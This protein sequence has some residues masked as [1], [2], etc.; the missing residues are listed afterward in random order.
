MSQQPENTPVQKDRTAVMRTLLSRP[1]DL[2]TF[3]QT[4]LQSFQAIYEATLAGVAKPQS[5]DLTEFVKI[6][7]VYVKGEAQEHMGLLF[8]SIYNFSTAQYNASYTILTAL[9]AFIVK[10]QADRLVSAQKASTENK[11]PET[12]DL[13]SS[14]NAGAGKIRYLGGRCVAKYRYALMNRIKS[15]MYSKRDSYMQ[16]RKLFELLTV[17][18]VSERELQ[19]NSDNVD[20]LH[21]TV[22]RQNIRQAL[23]HVSD[24]CFQFFCELEG[25][26]M[27][28]ETADNFAVHGK[29]ILMYVQKTALESP[30][31]RKTW[32][33]LFSATLSCEKVVGSD[34]PIWTVYE[35]MVRRYLAIASNQFRKALVESL[36]PT[37][38]LA[39]RIQVQKSSATPSSRAPTGSRQTSRQKTDQRPPAPKKFKGKSKTTGKGKGHLGRSKKSD[40]ICATCSMEYIEGTSVNGSLLGYMYQ[41]SEIHALSAA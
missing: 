14:T 40:D 13:T 31:L 25:I 27:S 16:E 35:E 41:C 32:A 28:V 37:K 20:S 33:A 7:N 1:V 4:A 29:S 30:A 11:Q 19:A 12:D 17:L 39:H 10:K 5:K 23:T 8:P 22:R 6:C 3:C 38:V 34:H 18:T 2:T 26:R 15:H 36:R 24:A 21:E 9:R